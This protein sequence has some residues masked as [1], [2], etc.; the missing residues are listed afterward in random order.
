M[1]KY[2]AVIKLY[3]SAAAEITL[4]ILGQEI[5]TETRSNPARPPRRSRREEENKAPVET[6]VEAGETPVEAAGPDVSETLPK[7]DE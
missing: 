7:A 5:R 2:K 6:A 1:G 4:T 3:E